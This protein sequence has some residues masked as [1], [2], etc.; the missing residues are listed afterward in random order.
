MK[1]VS[2]FSLRDRLLALTPVLLLAVLGLN[3]VRLHA[4]EHLSSWRGGGFGMFA[5]SDRD[6]YR[7]FVITI[8]PAAAAPLRVN[9]NSF[10]GGASQDVN[11]TQSLANTKSLPTQ[12]ALK[13]LALQLLQAKWTRDSVGLNF[14]GWTSQLGTYEKGGSV[15]IDVYG[16]TYNATTNTVEPDLLTSYS[17]SGA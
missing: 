10:T 6:M 9:L 2:D 8:H 7:T 13:E 5:N 11:V 1:S 12:A 16:A 17:G 15:S 3:E 4:S 14:Q